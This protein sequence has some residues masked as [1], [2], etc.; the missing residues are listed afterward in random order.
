MKRSSMLALVL[1]GCS[2][3]TDEPSPRPETEGPSMVEQ[4]PPVSRT[5][6]R[7]VTMHRRFAGATPAQVFAALTEPELLRRWMSAA[8]RKLAE[9]EV[10][11]R[12]GGSY[13]HTFVAPG[14][15]PFVMY[16]EYRDVVPGRR[17][18]HTEAYEGYDWAPLVVTTELAEAGRDTV[19]TVIVEYPSK[20]ICDR[21][22]P[23]LEHASAGYDDLAAL[24]GQHG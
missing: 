16:G 23:N 4:G 2:A 11:P 22:M 8:G 15:K 3:A 1:A 19:M 6:E 12:S 9:S 21:D 20:A 14:R 24:L 18:V 7:E 5:G 13:R 10:D 17:I